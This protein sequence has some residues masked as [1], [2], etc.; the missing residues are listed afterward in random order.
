[1]FIEQD[2]ANVFGRQILHFHVCWPEAA[3]SWFGFACVA[4][5]TV[6]KAGIQG[7]KP[8]SNPVLTGSQTP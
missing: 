5:L 6:R 8:V 4:K 3:G 7:T 2:G 1:M